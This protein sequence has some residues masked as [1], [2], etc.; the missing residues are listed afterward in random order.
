MKPFLYGLERTHEQRLVADRLLSE[1]R[2]Y[3]AAAQKHQPPHATAP[4]RFDQWV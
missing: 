3:A 1:L 2:V 4:S